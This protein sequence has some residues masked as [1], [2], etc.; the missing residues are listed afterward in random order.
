V[1]RC[2]HAAKAS[3]SGIGQSNAAS[4]EEEEIRRSQGQ[5][6]AQ[7]QGREAPPLNSSQALLADQRRES[8][9]FSESA[10]SGESRWPLALKVEVEGE[11]RRRRSVPVC[12]FFL[13]PLPDLHSSSS[14]LVLSSFYGLRP[15]FFLSFFWLLLLLLLAAGSAAESEKKVIKRWRWPVSRAGRVRALA[16]LVGSML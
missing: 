16:S 4:R 10:T 6:R 2:A 15:F 1:V 12:F 3:L 11:I 9:P 14:S 7:E 5:A 8:E 13:C